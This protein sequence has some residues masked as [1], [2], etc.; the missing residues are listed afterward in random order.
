LA[1]TIQ[2]IGGVRGEVAAWCNGRAMADEPSKPPKGSGS[3]G[4]LV[5]AESIFQLALAVPVGAFVGLGIGYLLDR[6]FHTGWIAVTLLLVGAAGGMIQ[7][8]TYLARN[9]KGGEE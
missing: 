8:F 6:H 4:G 7:L 5:K 3:L 1:L 2:Y 9:S